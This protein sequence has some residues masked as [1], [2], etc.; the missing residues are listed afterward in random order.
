VLPLLSKPVLEATHLAVVAEAKHKLNL[1]MVGRHVNEF[2]DVCP[3][4]LKRLGCKK[5]CILIL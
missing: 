1:K 5:Y 3:S 4:A 2:Y